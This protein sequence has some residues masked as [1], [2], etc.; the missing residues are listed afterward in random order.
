M[1]AAVETGF[2]DRLQN[3]KQRPAEPTL[4][5]TYLEC[6]ARAS[7]PPGLG[8]Q[9]RRMSPGRKRSASKLMA[10]RGQKA[11]RLRFGLLDRL[12][13][14][15][16]GAPLVAYYVQQRPCEIC[17]GRHLLQQ[18]I[19]IGRPGGRTCRCLAPRCVQQ[20]RPVLGC[21]RIPSV[22]A[23][24]RAV[25]E[26]EAQLTVSRPFQ[27]HLCFAQPAF[28]GVIAPTKRSDF[29]HGHRPVVV[30]SSGPTAR[31]DPCRP[32]WVR[33]LDVPP[34]P[35]PLPPRPRLDFGRCVWRHAHPAGPACSG[36]HLRSVLRFASGFFSTRPH[37][38]RAGVSRRHLPA[39]SCLRLAVATNSPREGLSPPIQCPCQAHLP[40]RRP[41]T[42]T[43]VN[44][45]Q[46]I[47][48]SETKRCSDEAGHLTDPE[49]DGVV[50]WRCV[51]LR[52]KIANQFSVTFHKRSV[53]RLLRKLDL[54]RL[55]PRPHHP[56]KDAATQEAFKKTSPA[57]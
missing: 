50:R 46:S 43:H 55:Q 41:P 33:A 30:A 37:G 22:V 40:A 21:V 20:P 53:A 10:Q 19:R 9:T 44:N 54:T 3:L 26:H 36:V 6:R 49:K 32:P 38:A 51:D 13:H 23:P 7:P 25:G 48:L 52:T 24:L 17:L 2:V 42:A 31:A 39:C 16:P 47:H 45:R 4:V 56:K 29:L 1:T 8:I 34:P 57:W 14:R 35:P 5:A 12:G 27:N 15:T 11:R 28:T 18:P